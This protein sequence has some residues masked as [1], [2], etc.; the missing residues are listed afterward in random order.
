MLHLSKVVGVLTCIYEFE[1]F[2]CCL[3]HGDTNAQGGFK[4]P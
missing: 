3:S 1:K 4:A 2:I